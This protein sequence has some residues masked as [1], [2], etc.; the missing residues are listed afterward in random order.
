MRRRVV[1]I[2]V[3]VAFIASVTWF[4][5]TVPVHPEHRLR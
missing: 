5:T 4:M 3:A 1:A 2:G